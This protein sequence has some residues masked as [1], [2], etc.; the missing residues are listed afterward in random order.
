MHT[1]ALWLLLH[2]APAFGLQSGLWVSVATSKFAL[3]C[4]SESN[5]L[6]SGGA[7]LSDS[8]E[9]LP[10]M[11]VPQARQ[12]PQAG[13]SDMGYGQDQQRMLLARTGSDP[14]LSLANAP[15]ELLVSAVS[16]HPMNAVSIYAIQCT[17]YVV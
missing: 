11:H 13:P 16:A 5:E 2:N 12:M 3:R 7:G 4:H 6:V 1:A 14:I 9:G 8:Y 10:D 15:S 17:M